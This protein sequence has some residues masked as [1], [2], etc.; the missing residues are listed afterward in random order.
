VAFAARLLSSFRGIFSPKSCHPAPALSLSAVYPYDREMEPHLS[1]EIQSMICRHLAHG[2][3]GSP[4]SVI[5]KALHALNE[6]E[7][8]AAPREETGMDA[9][10]SPLLQWLCETSGPAIDLDALR[11][12]LAGISG[13]LSDAIAEER[14]GRL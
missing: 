3:S 7:A 2:C 13:S 10:A 8:A 9:Q 11:R 5:K 12:R 4:E 1:P 14:Q 6:R